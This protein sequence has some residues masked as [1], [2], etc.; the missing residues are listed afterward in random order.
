MSKFFVPDEQI[1][2]DKITIKGTDV[3]HIKNVLRKKKGDILEIC[4]SQSN[5][6]FECEIIKIENDKIETQII[7]KES[8]TKGK[9]KIT[10][11]QG[12]PKFD[13]MELVIQKSVELG[14]YQITPI[15]LERCIV[16]IKNG[17]RIKKQERWQK[18]SEVAAKQCGQNYIPKI[19][20]IMNIK[21]I[22][23]RIS[24]YD[25]FICAYENEKKQ[26]LKSV[27]QEIKN[28][29]LENINVAIL[30]GPEGGISEKEI[31]LLREN[32][33]KIVTLGDRIL[34]T[35][36]VALNVLSILM[37]ELEE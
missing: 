22:C 20:E 15:E 12:L 14:A 18:I 19:N 9:A 25:V 2:E 3:N 13:K 32:N 35:E 5:I 37:Y 16:K 21:E 34:R 33:A 30:I 6:N 29:N 1:E 26:T 24:D 4:N 11:M 8:N 23:S 10:I 27:I 36:T 31:T 17:D 28:M 7:N